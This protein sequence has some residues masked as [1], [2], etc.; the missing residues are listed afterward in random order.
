MEPLETSNINDIYSYVSSDINRQKNNTSRAYIIGIDGFNGSGK[1]YLAEKIMTYLHGVLFSLDCYAGKN[2]GVYLNNFDYERLL[3]EFNLINQ[4]VRV[5]IFEGICLLNILEK[6]D[7]QLDKLI[8]VKHFSS[9]GFWIDDRLC[10]PNI[11]LEEALSTIKRMET[12][13]PP[14]IGNLEREIAKYHHIYNPIEKSQ[15]LFHRVDS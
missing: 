8:Y 10:D 14:G 15:I 12:N 2:T 7:I 3:K 1:S 13:C 5:I 9:D 4:D 6:I 11:T